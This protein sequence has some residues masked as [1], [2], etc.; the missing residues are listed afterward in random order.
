MHA[1]LICPPFDGGDY[2]NLNIMGSIFRWLVLFSVHV[3]FCRTFFSYFFVKKGQKQ[4]LF[5]L[6]YKH[7]D[8]KE[9]S[10]EFF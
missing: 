8:V 2:M 4:V 3:Q 6:S 7:E 5:K 10:K 9:V 1:L